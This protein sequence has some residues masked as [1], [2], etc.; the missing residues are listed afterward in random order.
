[1]IAPK[2]FCEKCGKELISVV[3]IDSYDYK[4]GEPYYRAY[5]QCVDKRFWNDHDKKNRFMYKGD[6]Q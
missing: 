4:T 6:L 1:M 5:Y 2:Q 3:K